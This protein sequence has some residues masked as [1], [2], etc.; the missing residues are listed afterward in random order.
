MKKCFQTI[1]K[2]LCQDRWY[3]TINSNCNL[4]EDQIPQSEMDRLNKSTIRNV[5]KSVII[6]AFFNLSFLVLHMAKEA[7]TQRDLHMFLGN[8]LFT[9]CSVL[10]LFFIKKFP[11]YIQTCLFLCNSFGILALHFFF[12]TDHKG[13]FNCYIPCAYCYHYFTSSLAPSKRHLSS[14]VFTISVLIHLYCTFLK[15]GKLDNDILVSSFISIFYFDFG[16]GVQQSK[17]A[18]MYAMILENKKLAGEKQKVVQ[19]FPHP[20]LII[21]EKLTRLS[22]CYSNDQFESQIKSLN[23]KIEELDQVKV[24]IKKKEEEQKIQKANKNDKIQLSLYKYLK[25]SQNK[26][27]EFRAEIKDDIIIEC[28]NSS[29]NLMENELE[30]L[31]DEQQKP[32]KPHRNF[33]IKSLKLEWKGY[34]SFMHVFIDHTNIINLEQAKNRIKMQRIMF[35]SASHEF[36]TPLNAIIHSYNFIKASFEDF[37]EVLKRKVPGKFFKSRRIEEDI[38]HILKFTKTGATSSVLLMSLVEDILNLSKIDNGTL[39]TVFGYFNISELL[40]EVHSLFVVQCE[41]KNIALTFECEGNLRFCEVKTDRN[42]LRQVLLNLVS[43]SVKF[44]YNGYVSVKAAV[45]KTFDGNTFVEFSV[46]DTG[47]GIKEE[48]Q[49]RLFKLFGMI[50]DTN[51]LNPDGC[52]LGLTVSKKYIEILGG[53]IKVKSEYGVGTEMIFTIL[54]KDIKN[55]YEGVR[56]P[57]HNFAH[58]S[59]NPFDSWDVNLSP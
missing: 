48:D 19:E 32:S 53:D 15:I 10:S 29:E 1:I 49:V 52:G 27:K 2:Y 44:T 33:S 3:N 18:D 16:L 14:L 6:L 21:P 36:R 11:V 26:P 34:M 59:P 9:L 58:L 17:L 8:V 5:R 41:N 12:Q 23:H 40:N 43:N 28:E 56:R 13:H 37:I 38:E 24:V 25:Q 50:E 31:N 20:V 51:N 30:S 57:L 39:T 55:F 46:K 47:I 45:T 7:Q 42:R 35:A 4:S 22:Q 54:P